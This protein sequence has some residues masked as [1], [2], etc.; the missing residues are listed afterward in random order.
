MFDDGCE[1]CPALSSDGQ[2][3]LDEEWMEQERMARPMNMEERPRVNCNWKM[4]RT[5]KQCKSLDRRSMAISHH[6][7]DAA[8]KKGADEKWRS[9]RTDH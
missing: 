6:R 8:G 5:F 9:G 7:T 2:R 1:V 4:T 3:Y